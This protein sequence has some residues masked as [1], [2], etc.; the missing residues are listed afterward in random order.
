LIK[1]LYPSY[2]DNL[3][4]FTY[5]GYQYLAV[6]TFLSLAIS[7][8]LYNKFKELKTVNLIIAPLTIWLIICTLV[9]VYLEGASF[10]ILPAFAGLASFYILINQ[11]K[12]NLILLTLL[13]FPAVWI[14]SPL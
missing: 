5:N 14:L 9:A 1:M 13:A 4:G 12:P 11:S 7:F 8:S 6:F 2:H 3:H 10:F